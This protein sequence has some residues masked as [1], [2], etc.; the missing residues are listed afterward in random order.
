VGG[1]ARW[2]TKRLIGSKAVLSICCINGP[3][4]E[5]GAPEPQP[6]SPAQAAPAALVTAWVTTAVK[7]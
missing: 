4:I 2:A 1:V 5:Q 6:N 7:F 3:V